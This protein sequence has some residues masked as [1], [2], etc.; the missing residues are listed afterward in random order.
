PRAFKGYHLHKI[1]AARY[2]CLKGIMTII[3]FINEKFERHI[4]KVGDSL[5]IPKNVPTGLLNEGSE[6]GW[7][8]NYP[9]PP[10]DPSLK[11][12]QVDYTDEELK[13]GI[14]K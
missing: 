3:L 12:E 11:D 1:R 5:T 7:L 13:K 9:D 14:I 10:Y 6:E 4:L 2:V 8:I